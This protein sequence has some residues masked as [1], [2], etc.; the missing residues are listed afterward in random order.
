MSDENEYSRRIAARQR[1]EIEEYQ[2][3][4]LRKSQA[5]LDASWQMMLDLAAIEN[6]PS[7]AGNYSPVRR[8][9]QEMDDAQDAADE[10]FR[11]RR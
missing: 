2:R 9:E 1:Q 8:F 10:I 5:A 11:Q 7:R 6:S 3:D 4:P